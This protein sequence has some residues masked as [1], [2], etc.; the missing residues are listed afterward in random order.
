M[1]GGQSPVVVS[2]ETLPSFRQDA[3][4]LQKSFVLSDG[5]AGVE[6]SSARREKVMQSPRSFLSSATLTA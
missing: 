3:T 6:S 4:E 5:I 2:H 1:H